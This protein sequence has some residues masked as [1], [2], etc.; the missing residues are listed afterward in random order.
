MNFKYIIIG[1][2]IVFVI[3]VIYLLRYEIRWFFKAAKVTQKNKQSLK[4]LQNEG[5][6]KRNLSDE[7][8]KNYIKMSKQYLNQLNI[9]INREFILN[10]ELERHLRYSRFSEKYVLELFYEILNHMGVNEKELKLKINYMSS[11]ANIGYAG[12]YSEQ[13]EIKDVILNIKNN[14]TID[15]IISVLA[16]E[17]THHLLLS[18]GIKLKERIENECLTDVTTILLGFEKYMFEGYKISNG[19]KFDTINTRL[20]DK[21][22]VG[23]LTS[24]DIQYVGK[25]M[26]KV[27]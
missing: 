13:N 20:V 3:Y 25:V 23:Y 5:V 16:H 4:N 14:M 12:L 11:K 17:S 24:K 7:Q 26:R 1:A 2:I 27:K 19:V 21:N 18:N 6:N 9:E 22:R 10:Q 15:T 8:L